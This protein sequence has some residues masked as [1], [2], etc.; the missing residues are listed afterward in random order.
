MIGQ[1]GE[2]VPMLDS[3]L[4]RQIDNSYHGRKPA[5]WLLGLFVL[6]KMAQSVSVLVD[7]P[8]VL[9]SADGI[10]LDTFGPA[11]AQTVVSVWTLLALTRLWIFLAGLL[12]LA[13]YRS[14][15]PFMFV[16]LLLVDFGRVVVLQFLPIARIGT[17]A[18]PIVNQLLLA[19]AIIGLVLSLGRRRDPTH[20]DNTTGPG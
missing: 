16:F 17:P 3:I 8:A 19:L 2:D 5:L 11:A 12:V 6:V 15:V 14:L 7:G 13:R 4:P 1:A 10:P 20:A 9:S 18:A